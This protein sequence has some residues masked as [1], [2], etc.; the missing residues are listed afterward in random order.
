MRHQLKVL[1]FVVVKFVTNLQLCGVTYKR[2][3]VNFF[4]FR[5][6]EQRINFP[7]SLVE[8]VARTKRQPF[9]NVYYFTIYIRGLE[10]V[11]NLRKQSSR[12]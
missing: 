3:V 10:R 4:T 2:S 5:G 1:I 6:I 7:N 11:Y 9:V 8:L 12:S